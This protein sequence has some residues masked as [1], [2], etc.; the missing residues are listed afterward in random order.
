MS[1]AVRQSVVGA[2]LPADRDASTTRAHDS[3]RVLA[4]KLTLEPVRQCAW[5]LNTVPAESM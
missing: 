1:I 4:R 2:A 3:R 5:F